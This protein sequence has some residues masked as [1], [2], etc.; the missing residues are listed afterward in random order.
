MFS[1][2]LTAA[3]RTLYYT[4]FLVD[5]QRKE[6][7]KER[8]AAIQIDDSDD[9]AIRQLFFENILINDTVRDK[10]MSTHTRRY[11]S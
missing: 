2:F 3:Q 8:C 6:T 7:S 5:L 9:L 10:V 11:C 1:G 4:A